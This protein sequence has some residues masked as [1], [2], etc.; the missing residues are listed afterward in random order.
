MASDVRW[1]I[2][3]ADGRLLQ[4]FS[5]DPREIRVGW[6]SPDAPGK[7]KGGKKGPLTLRDETRALA[8][9]AALAANLPSEFQHAEVT[10]TSVMGTQI[11]K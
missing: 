10:T 6:F 5:I 4:S 1:I 8:L 3:K 7:K 2:K 11:S 9:L